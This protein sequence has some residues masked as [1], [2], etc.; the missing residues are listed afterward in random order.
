MIMSKDHPNLIRP[1]PFP[2]ASMKKAKDKPYVSLP[3]KPFKLI[4]CVDERAIVIPWLSSGAKWQELKFALRAIHQFFE[5]K[6]CPIYIIGDAAPT[7]LKEGGRV[8]FIHIP[9]YSKGNHHGL[10]AAWQIGVQ[11]AHVVGWWN[12]D[13]YLLKPTSW[14]DMAVAL[15][16][17]PLDEFESGLRSSP[18]SWRQALGNAVAELKKRGHEKVLRFATHTPFLF[19]AEKSREIMREYYL[20]HKGSWVTLYH[21]HHK[22][23]NEPCKP[24]KTMTLPCAGS[25]RYLN[26]RD[27]GPD[28]STKNQLVL[29][30]S[31]PAPWEI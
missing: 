8:R 9:E 11:I 22:T 6:E 21:N 27:G 4:D 30:F 1:S 24:H 3:P 29:L 20:H 28:S 19:E 25:P 17:G 14:K 12:D 16:E 7:W 13:I 10:W 5:D 18:N 26:H 2:T 15:H 31:N 23:P